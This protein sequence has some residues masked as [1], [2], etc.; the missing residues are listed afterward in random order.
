MPIKKQKSERI[1]KD[2]KVNNLAQVVITEMR[3]FFRFGTICTIQKTPTTLLKVSL[4][5]GYFS[6][7]SSDVTKSRKA[8]QITIEFTRIR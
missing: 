1:Q 3:R 7:F 8:S 2:T 6:C 4:L 5:H